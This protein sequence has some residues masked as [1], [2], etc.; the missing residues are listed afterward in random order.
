[1]GN[2]MANKF[3]SMILVKLVSEYYLCFMVKKHGLFIKYYKN[4]KKQESSKLC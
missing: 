2:T 3:I 4:G 1:M